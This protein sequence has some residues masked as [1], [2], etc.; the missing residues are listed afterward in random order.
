MLAGA[1]GKECSHPIAVAKLIHER[2]CS[3][4]FSLTG[5]NLCENGAPVKE[6]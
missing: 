1:I 3:P 6:S 4:F 5:K 2:P